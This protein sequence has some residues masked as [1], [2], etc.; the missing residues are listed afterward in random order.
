MTTEQLRP[1][2]NARRAAE[3]TTNSNA[4]GTADYQ[5]NANGTADDRYKGDGLSLH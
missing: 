2:V 4:N 1:N 3:L 5:I